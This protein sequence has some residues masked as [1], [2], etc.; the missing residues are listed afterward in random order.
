M[1]EPYVI[2]VDGEITLHLINHLTFINKE[3]VTI[4]RLYGDFVDVTLNIKEI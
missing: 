2:E 4:S 3:E 1:N